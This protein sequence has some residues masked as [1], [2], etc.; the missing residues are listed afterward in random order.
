MG[1]CTHKP[2]D[3]KEGIQCPKSTERKTTQTVEGWLRSQAK[4]CQTILAKDRQDGEETV[5]LV[6]KKV[7]YA[8]KGEFL[9]VLP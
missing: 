1:P 5:H 6:Q 2:V 4:T 7:Q 8:K 9:T 3:E